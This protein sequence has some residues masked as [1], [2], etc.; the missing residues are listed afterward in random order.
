M[1]PR[2]TLVASLAGLLSLVVTHVAAAQMGDLPHTPVPE[3]LPSTAVPVFVEV[4]PTLEVGHAY[5]YYKGL[6]M[7]D[8]RRIEMTRVGSGYGLEIPC[9]DVFEPAMEYYIVLFDRTGSPAGFAGTRSSPIRVPIVATR[10]HPAPSLPGRPAPETC[11]EGA[12]GGGAGS[13]GT[14]VGGS[15]AI[16]GDCST[17]LRCDDGICLLPRPV[18]AGAG[19]AACTAA[20]GAH[21]AATPGER[22]ATAMGGGN[23]GRGLGVG[24]MS[25]LALAGLL[26]WR[27][28]RSG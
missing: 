16:D 13:V 17:G 6:G 7:P 26:V 11:T 22:G 28:R 14:S 19:C 9:T 4:P 25:L 12:A 8:F 21:N 18:I 24:G 2:K 5:V 1:S 15:C 23:D 10:T 3:Q 27:S 20:L